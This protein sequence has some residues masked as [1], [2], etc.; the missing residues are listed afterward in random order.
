[1]DKDLRLYE[2][3]KYRYESFEKKSIIIDVNVESNDTNFT[4]T[5]DEP[6]V[7]DVRSQVYL[8]S[9][10]TYKCKDSSDSNLAGFLLSIDIFPTKAVSN[11]SKIN[12]A[13]FIP[14]EHS[15]NVVIGK[16]HKGKKLNYVCD[17][18]PTKIVQING[19]LTDI[20]GCNIFDTPTAVNPGRFIA[21][22]I[23]TSI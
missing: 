9:L 6:L 14:N 18:N 22:F 15:T 4:I 13:F 17:I 3:T 8:D 19:S 10:T 16:V 20:N 7:I 2:N 21:E 23:I 5:M 12:R 11:N 1:M